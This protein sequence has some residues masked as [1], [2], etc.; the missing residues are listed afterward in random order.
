MFNVTRRLTT[1]FRLPQS[2]GFQNHNIWLE[3]EQKDPARKSPVTGDKLKKV[4]VKEE[5]SET[6]HRMA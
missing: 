1:E 6:M 4:P 3:G 2:V 5:S